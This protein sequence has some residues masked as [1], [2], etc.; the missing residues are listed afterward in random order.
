MYVAENNDV[1]VY[2]HIQRILPVRAIFDGPGNVGAGAA[3]LLIRLLPVYP[4]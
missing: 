4:L 2:N 1:L 3:A